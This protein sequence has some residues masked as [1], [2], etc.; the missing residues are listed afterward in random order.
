MSKSNVCSQFFIQK[1]K[2]LPAHTQ[3]NFTRCEPHTIQTQCGHLFQ[4]WIAWRCAMCA[5][6]ANHDLNGLWGLVSSVCGCMQLVF[7][8]AHVL[9]CM[10]SVCMCL[11]GVGFWFEWRNEW[12]ITVAHKI[13]RKLRTRKWGKSTGESHGQYNHRPTS[14]FLTDQPTRQLHS[15]KEISLSDPVL[16][17]LAEMSI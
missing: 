13:K 17:S 4:S 15:K 3:R 14:C 10:Q 1:T 9:M 6:R 8:L 2:T 16:L 5:V 11:H 12:G 7:V